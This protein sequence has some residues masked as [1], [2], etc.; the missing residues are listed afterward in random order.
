[1][2]GIIN[3]VVSAVVC[4][5]LVLSFLPSR[6][7]LGESSD[8]SVRSGSDGVDNR[9]DESANT[10]AATI[11]ADQGFDSESVSES[12]MD[13]L[14]ESG[15]ESG[16]AHPSDFSEGAV[17]GG[18]LSSSL[19]AL[20]GPSSRCVV[21]GV[22]E[23][24]SAV[25]E[26]RALDIPGGSLEDCAR[27]QLWS[28][29]GSLAQRFRFSY[30]EVSG[31]YTITNIGSGKV[32]D[33]AGGSRDDGT[34]VQQYAA[35]GTAAQLW[36]VKPDGD[37]FVIYSAIDAGQVIDVTEAQAFDGAG[38]QLYGANGTYAQ[39]WKLT[40]LKSVE[41][42]R[43]INGGVYTISS[44]LA[45]SLVVDIA[46]AS[47]E[48]GGNA[49]LYSANLTAAQLFRVTLGD[50]GFYTIANLASGKV[51]DVSD[52]SY[53]YGA[54][55]QQWSANASD[56]QK[57][58]I[59][60]NGDGSYSVVSKLGTYLDVSGAAAQ[61]GA[62][63]Q[64]WQRNETFAQSFRFNRVA[65]SQ[66]VPD[67]VYAIA[68]ALDG[69]K[70]LDVYGGSLEDCAKVQLWGSNNTSAQRFRFTYDE[71]SGFYEI[72]ND[73]SG[74]VLDAASGMWVDGTV[75]QQYSPNGTAAQMWAVEPDGEGYRI[76]SVLNRGQALDVPCADASDGMG[77][78][79]YGANGTAAQRWNLQ[80][81]SCPIDFVVNCGGDTI[82]PIDKHDGSIYLT[83]PSHASSDSV[84]L[85][86]SLA[87]GN[88]ACIGEVKI[89][90]D[91]SLVSLTDIGLNVMPGEE[92]SCSITDESGAVLY[93]LAVIRSSDCASMFLSSADV[94]HGRD[95]VESSPDH[96]ASAKGDLR[97]LNVEG[98]PIY[99]GKLEQIK[100]RGNS[101]WQLADKKP[102]Q[103]KL[104]KKT[105]LLESGD[106]SNKNKTWVLLAN[107]F[108]GSSMRNMISCSLA[109]DIGVK[110]SV[111]FRPVDLYYDGE[112]RGTYL[113]TE[114]VQINA[115]RVDIA[116][117][118]E[119][120]EE[121]NEDEPVTRDVEG[122][123][124]YGHPMKYTEG[125]KSP[126]D[127]SGGYLIELDGR[128]ADER[129]WFSVGTQWG[130][131]YFVCKSPEGWTY[132]EA[133]YLSCYVQDAFD[134]M[135][136]GGRNPRTGK[137]TGDYIDIDSFTSLYWVNEI[138][139]NRDGFMFSSTYAY[140]DSGA[141]GSDSRLV[142]GP[143]WDFD[144][145]LGS[146]SS[147]T[148][149]PTSWVTDPTGWY[150]RATGI[151]PLFMRD[152]LVLKTVNV[153][154]DDV[155]A[156]SKDYLVAELSNQRKAV[157]SSMRLNSVVWGSSGESCDDVVRWLDQ[158]L[159]WLS[160]VRL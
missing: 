132:E 56:A 65:S 32:L 11:G 48:D 116:N 50:D 105:D 78:Q 92:A 75:V 159:D 121:V 156:A 28:S 41:G 124:S 70:V 110:S 12:A 2:N 147:P 63:L 142:F 4:T 59:A 38:I 129:S 13:E 77:I 1:M 30:D 29:N 123:N 35:N 112:Y 42:G 141:S 114:K 9:F 24:S 148:G 69:S 98:E 45:D 94:Q 54:N 102:Y 149:E 43:S 25:D 53:S 23:L 71:V 44:A 84:L 31:F 39:R 96:S 62:N 3:K 16:R 47:A 136:N 86:V 26:S 137:T 119:E 73:G 10:D 127:I 74:K 120:N 88:V 68:S 133:N 52:G 106:V 104:K 154:R 19:F 14:F 87:Y 128:Y 64:T 113:L 131:A 82:Y 36:G 61:D 103:I 138:T 27:A 126:S 40:E 90:R 100:G 155:V 72:A 152:P 144:L 109:R 118:E 99:D 81:S 15:R 117:L 67:G 55:V 17:E 6:V 58:V 18:R 51:L 143:A 57:W 7:A 22:Y 80:Y 125:L 46:S 139:K 153:A 111:E 97:M 145:S 5:A 158:R 20:D 157:E 83:L 8:L 66:S 79:L 60:D 49:Q 130:P 150:T 134:A 33:A 85:S 89:P 34:I 108:D 122:L 76:C 93:S 101:T 21:D 115:G 135:A 107:A 95:Y 140:K 37:G 91:G 151:A 146:L 160:N